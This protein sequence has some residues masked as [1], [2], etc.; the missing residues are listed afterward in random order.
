MIQ[1]NYKRKFLY[2]ALSPIKQSNTKTRNKSLKPKDTSN[3]SLSPQIS[4]LK[5]SFLHSQINQK[6]PKRNSTSTSISKIKLFNQYDNMDNIIYNKKFIQ[7]DTYNILVAVRIRPLNQKEEL[8]STEETISVENKNTILLKDPNGYINP[9]NIRAKEQFLTFDYVFDK[10][11]TQENIFNNTTKFLINGVVNGYNSTVFA[12]GATGAGKTYTMLGNDENPGIMIYTLKELFKEIKSYPKREFKIKLWYLE[13]YNENIKD[14]LI[15]NSENLE[16][17]EDPIKGLIINGITEKE[18]N[19]SEDILSLLKKGN[20]NR[21]IEET[22]SNETSSRSHAILQILVSYREK[23]N[24]INNINTINISNININN[25]IKF[26]KLSLIDLAGSER[27]SISGSKG[28]RLIEGGNINRSL[29]VLGNCINALCE[30]NI[31][32]NKP[33]IPYRDSKLT[34][35]L[36]DSLGGNSRTVMIANVSPFIY[37]FYDTYNT[38]KY[39]ERAKYIKNKINKNIINYNS[40]YLRNNYLNV[41]RKLH[42]KIYDLENR[43]LLY[44]QNKKFLKISE[45]N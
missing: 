44:E 10:N 17:R 4:I 25:D 29:L 11:E 20:K 31:K 3:L 45:I 26:G 24:K 35:L 36:K 34:R 30:S 7:K 19:S 5:N 23:E 32:G 6:M 2:L 16:L 33:H 13:I 22:D 14:L 21:T 40:Q 8:I 41:I 12:Y 38:L 39:A 9:N 42:G 37:N 27:V 43:L 28:M 1:S 18:T 15:N